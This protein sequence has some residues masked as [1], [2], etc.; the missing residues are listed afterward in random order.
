MQMYRACSSFARLL[1]GEVQRPAGEQPSVIDFL[2]GQPVD[3]GS[4]LGKG[5]NMQR[6]HLPWCTVS[7]WCDVREHEEHEESNCADDD[8]AFHA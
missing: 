4:I 2:T 7:Q 5:M 6:G 1:R 3:E 8:R